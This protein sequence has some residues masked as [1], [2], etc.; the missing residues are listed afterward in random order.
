MSDTL[1]SRSPSRRKASAAHATG[2]TSLPPPS[3]PA[4]VDYNIERDL[5]PSKKSSR[6][7]ERNKDSSNGKTKVERGVSQS[8]LRGS[9]SELMAFKGDNAT[10]SAAEYEKVCMGI[11]NRSFIAS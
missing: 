1:A 7:R 4:D 8:D 10:R 6:R 3:R 11:Q 9:S 2:Y 5:L